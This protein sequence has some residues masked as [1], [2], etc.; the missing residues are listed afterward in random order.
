MAH[1]QTIL[2]IKHSDYDAIEAAV[3]ETERGRWFL[4]EYAR[5]NRN[6]DTDA[7]LRAIDNL[8]GSFKSNLVS[9]E[10]LS[11]MAVAIARTKSALTPSSSPASEED[12]LDHISRALKDS[13]ADIRE[14]TTQLESPATD[15]DHIRFQTTRI[16]AASDVQDGA[17]RRIDRIIETLRY[18]ETR[19]NAMISTEETQELQDPTCGNDVTAQHHTFPRFGSAGLPH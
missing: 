16:A 13:A 1:E 6:A 17:I 2:A 18:L 7:V 11:D 5:R 9:R 10:N 4:K 8:G 3:M 19:I 14:A 12:E 15:G